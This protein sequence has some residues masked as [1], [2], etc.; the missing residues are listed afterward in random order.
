[1]EDATFLAK[2]AGKV[3]VVHRR[4]EFRASAIMLQ[5]AKDTDNIELLTPYVVKSFE[6]GE[7]GALERRRSSRTPRTA[8]PR[9]SPIKGAFIAIGHRPNSQLVEGQLELDDEGYVLLGG[10]LHPHQARRASLPRAT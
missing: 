10:T 2:F 3:T 4:P 5:R 1:M 6:A 9:R 7:G 8:R